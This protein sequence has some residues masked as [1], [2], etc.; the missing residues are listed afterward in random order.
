MATAGRST[1]A[2]GRRMN[3]D[4]AITAPVL[5]ALTK[6][7]AV[8]SRCSRRPRTMEESGF[9]RTAVAGD[10]DGWIRSDAWMM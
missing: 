10:S 9:R 5:P 7:S 3:R 4:A 2:T 6:A 1:P 8:P